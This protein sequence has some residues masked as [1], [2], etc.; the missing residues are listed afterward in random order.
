MTRSLAAAL[1]LIILFLLIQ[2]TYAGELTLWNKL[3]S[4]DEV[5]NSEVGP[6]LEF[7]TSGG[8]GW[9][10][11]GDR[12]YIPAVIDN[13]VTLAGGP[14]PSMGRVHN[15]V[16]NDFPSHIN[17]ERG[18]IQVYYKQI[19]DPIAY[20]HAVYRIFGGGY[21]FQ[22]GIGL[23]SDH[24]YPLANNQKRLIF[25]VGFNRAFHDNDSIAVSIEDGIMG[26]DI[27]PYN[28]QWILLDAVWDR[29]GI[30][31][32]VDAVRL[33][34][35]GKLV[36]K[37]TD[38]NWGTQPGE[39]LDICGGNDNN[40]VGKFYQ[41]EVKL[42]DYAKVPEPLFEE[43][44]DKHPVN[45]HPNY[46]SGWSVYGLNLVSAVIQGDSG[47]G[48]N[49]LQIE[50]NSVANDVPPVWM[51]FGIIQTTAWSPAKDFTDAT[52]EFDIQTDLTSAIEDVIALEISAICNETGLVE[53][54]RI[55]DANL[56]SLPSS[57][58]GWVKFQIDISELTFNE[59]SWKTPD[60]TQVEKV[61]LLVLQTVT[62]IVAG[63][64]VD[65]D[66]FRAVGIAHAKTITIIEENYNSY[67]IGSDPNLSSDWFVFGLERLSQIIQGANGDNWIDTAFSSPSGVA[68][69]WC[70][71]G[72]AQLEAWSVLKDFSDATIKVDVKTDLSQSVSNVIA[73]EIFAVC[74]ETGLVESF[75]IPDANLIDLPSSAEGWV[76]IEIDIS[77]LTHNESTWKTPDYSQVQ[78]I[79]VLF[80]Q[81]ATDM[82]ASGTVSIDNLKVE[83]S[84]Q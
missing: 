41:D 6:D 35:N 65:I 60:L 26:Y 27:T 69:A 77:E 80:L 30:N 11:V 31:G 8:F 63:G 22:E 10:Y 73:L 4:N 43:K 53:T 38:N 40:I 36:A 25:G 19:E 76:N 50:F 7:Y 59:A 32:S 75:R 45:S 64:T 82:V 62:D 33:Y 13:G 51:P 67:S 14:Y 24:I 1:G 47:S 57:A 16:L 23:Q 48:N 34:L 46:V 20:S 5:L 21:A 18:T 12:S 70:S 61:Q 79:Q 9:D 68:P 15:I 71:F 44:Y 58:E 56:L 28:G 49:W 84:A 52:I 2:A 3:G 37:S 66:D 42:W 81:T 29:D 78:K 83:K 55:P 72:L 17:T 74:N 39:M 54:F